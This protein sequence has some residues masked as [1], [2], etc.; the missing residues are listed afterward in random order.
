VE[1]SVGPVP[2]KPTPQGFT[3]CKYRN[4]FFILKNLACD[5]QVKVKKSS[6][7]NFFYS[8]TVEVGIKVF[9]NAHWGIMLCKPTCNCTQKYTCSLLGRTCDLN[10]LQKVR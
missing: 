1:L 6:T 5:T 7:D 3:L 8:L 9:G 2:V 10:S 4:G